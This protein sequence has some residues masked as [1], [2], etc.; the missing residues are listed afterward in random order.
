MLLEVH[1]ESKKYKHDKHANNEI[2]VNRIT[3]NYETALLC[4]F[5]ATQL[6]LQ[7]IELFIL[8]SP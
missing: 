2:E 1:R 4:K 5:I 6:L 7:A 8:S 3:N